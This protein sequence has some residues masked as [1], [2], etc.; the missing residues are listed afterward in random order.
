MNEVNLAMLESAAD[1]LDEILD[2]VVFVGGATV[3]LWVTDPAAPEFRPTNDVDVIVEITSRHAYYEL[4]ERLR[5]LRLVNDEE[6]GVICRFRRADSGLVL[7]VMPTESSILGFENRWLREAFP[8]GVLHALPSGREI[9]V[10]PPLYLL[11]TK[12]EAF[13]SRGRGDLYESKDFED[14]ITLIDGREELESEPEVAADEVRAF[15]SSGLARLTR[16][17]AFDSAAERALGG[18]PETFD[19]FELV[20]RPRIEALIDLPGS[21]GGSS[22]ERP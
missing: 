8:R 12:L 16:L 11:A 2:E 5:E 19:R 22:A 15:V 14:I 1:A 21:A 10:V 18:G 6:G 20:L 17:A 9:K 7:D 3:E 4:E 13:A